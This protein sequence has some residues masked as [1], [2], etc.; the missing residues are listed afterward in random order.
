MT[1]PFRLA[2]SMNAFNR[3]APAAAIETIA[4]IGYDG[5]E[6]MFDEPHLIPA[7]PDRAVVESIR[8]ALDRHWMSISNVN[9]F[10]MRMLGDTW[11]PSWIEPDESQ[12]RQRIDHTMAS[13]RL[14]ADL[15]APSISTEPGGPL[16]EGVARGDAMDT[17]LAGIAEVAPVAEETGVAILVEPEPDLLIETS[18]QFR[19]FIERVDS[20]A[21]ALNFDVGHFYCV[22]EDPVEAFGTLQPWVRHVHL[23]DIAE[24]REHRHL[25]PGDGAVDLAGMLQTLADAAYDGWVTV[26]LYPYQDDPEA[27]AARS[28]EVVRGLLADLMPPGQ[29]PDLVTVASF[30]TPV[31][32][33]LARIRLDDAGIDTFLADEHFAPMLGSNVSGG[34]KLQVRRTDVRRASRLL[35]AGPGE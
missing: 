34:V 15:G 25:A 6:V 8:E 14:A 21:V 30:A 32:A 28:H 7:A 20:P 31:E 4:A 9:A 24:T 27:V 17:F 2:F 11:H 33:G 13:L 16:P 10:T 1:P 5:V 18:D 23:E 35:G 3:F 19:D 22:G 12:R 29:A 26:E